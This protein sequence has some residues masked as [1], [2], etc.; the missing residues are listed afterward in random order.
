MNPLS[1]APPRSASEIK[2]H[3]SRISGGS[4]ESGGLKL[5]RVI[6]EADS[7]DLHDP[8]GPASHVLV[9]PVGVPSRLDWIT[10]GHRKSALFTPGDLILNPQGNFVSPRWNQAT[11]FLLLG[12]DSSCFTASPDSEELPGIDLFPSFHFRDELLHSLI[13]A[14][15]SNLESDSPDPLY[16]DV[17][18]QAFLLHLAKRHAA[19]PARQP[20]N[21]LPPRKLAAVREFIEERLSEELR[22]ED[23]SRHAGF[24]P[25]HFVTLFRRATGLAPHRYVMLRRIERAKRLLLQTNLPLAEIALHCG[26]SDQSHLTRV[27]KRHTGLTPRRLRD[28]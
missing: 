24:S 26:F 5:E 20:N 11:E 10:D 7:E 13:Q 23:L 12:L 3:L 21:A 22:L 8:A 19:R 18:T 9:V 6:E 14:L 17:L 27:V 28:A 25:S 4:H 15:M 16:A 1:H 2:P